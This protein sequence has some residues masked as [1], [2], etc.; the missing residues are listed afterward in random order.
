MRFLLSV[1]EGDQGRTH[2][3]GLA[4]LDYF[5][6]GCVPCCGECVFGE[7]GYL[8]GGY[9]YNGRDQEEFSGDSYLISVA[10]EVSRLRREVS[11]D[12]WEGRDA[13]FKRRELEYYERLAREGVIYEP[14]F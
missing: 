11:D 12:E 6:V 3:A 7:F 14:R 9:M 13:G 4:R 10:A 2:E 5:L 1:S 8:I